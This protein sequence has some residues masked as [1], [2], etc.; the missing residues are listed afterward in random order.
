M[1]RRAQ[2]WLALLTVGSSVFALVTTESHS[3]VPH[4]GK[5]P[6]AFESLTNQTRPQI[7]FIGRASGYRVTLASKEAIFSSNAHGGKSGKRCD[8]DAAFSKGVRS[9]PVSQNSLC[10]RSVSSFTHLSL[11]G[12]SSRI[13]PEGRKPL[14]TYSNYLI[15]NDPKRWTTH[16]PQFAEVWYPSTYPRIDLVYYGNDGKLEYDFVVAPYANPNR[17]RFAISTSDSHSRVRVNSAGDLVIPGGDGE[18]LF[19]KPVLFLGKSCSRAKS[20]P[21][22][23]EDDCKILQGGSF[24]VQY[25]KESTAIVSFRL[26]SYDRT[27]TLIIDPAVSFSTY[28]GGGFGDG[29]DGMALDSAGSIYL[30]GDTNSPDFPTTSGAYQ[31]NLSGD[32]DAF[33]T[34]LSPD[35]SQVLWS[36]YLGGTSGEYPTKIAVDSSGSVYVTGMTLSADFPVVNAF[37]SQLKIQDAFVSKLSPDG[38]KLIYS[39]Y[40]GGNSQDNAADIVVDEKGQAVVTGSTASLD[41][42]VAN[43]WQPTHAPTDNGAFD[44]FVTKFSA[45]GTSLIFSTYLGGNTNDEPR[46][47]RLDSADNVYV[48]GITGEG[49]PITPNAFQKV[50]VLQGITCAFVSKLSASGQDLVYSTFLND[51]QAFGIAVNAVGNAFVTGRAGADFPVTPGAFQTVPGLPSGDVDA[52]V[53]KLDPTGSSLVY[54][55]FLGGNNTDWGWA[56][57]VDPSDN[58]YVTGQTASTNFPLQSPVQSAAMGDPLIFVSELNNTGSA[59]LFS[60]YWG[61]SPGFGDQ[62]GNAIAVDGAGN[63]IT[64]GFATVPDFPVISAIQSQLQGPGDAV[65]FKVEVTPDFTLAGSPLS[66]TV[67]AGQSATYS[68]TLT[69]LNAFDQQVSL[70]CS[71]APSGSTC[72][73]SPST[74]TLDGVNPAPATV[75]VKTTA[76][77]RDG[78]ASSIPSSTQFLTVFVVTG[79][80]LAGPRVVRVGQRRIAAILIALMLSSG[81]LVSCG[82]GGST[83]GGGGGG[84]PPGTYTISVK[85]NGGSLNHDAKFTLVVK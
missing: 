18:I 45:D 38:S 19:H 28:L 74:L 69:P 53:T 17:I 43:A 44:G 24:R 10:A 62:Q 52:F 60:T 20:N 33:V 50:C 27:Q 35:G 41:F 79:L 14:R 76:Q 4:L 5:H 78:M 83:G 67:S 49:F 64:A 54:S 23:G 47:I 81:L 42:P 40:L 15:S 82:G 63:I 72:T 32:V 61:G 26:P 25:T 2:I 51:S 73:I 30:Y 13:N 48:A 22:D 37:Q 65:V 56:I 66:V 8:T 57:T 34:K 80:F 84:T 59:L 75:T 29:A 3:R 7:S 31:K 16:V 58:A 36:T 21:A 6:I 39:T 85:A 1:F 55:T 71:G 46:G 68:L 70:S 11:L 77:S 12:T 9:L